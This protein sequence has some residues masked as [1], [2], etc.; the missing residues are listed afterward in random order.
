MTEFY[1]KAH[2]SNGDD[3]EIAIKSADIDSAKKTATAYTQSTALLRG[4]IVESVIYCGCV[5]L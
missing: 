3:V 4:V 1:F 5:S 2:L